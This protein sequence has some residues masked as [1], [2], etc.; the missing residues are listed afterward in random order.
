MKPSERERLRSL[1]A[2]AALA[3]LLASPKAGI[4]A[5]WRRCGMTKGGLIV[6]ERAPVELMTARAPAEGAG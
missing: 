4:A 1:Y 5:G 6:L 2:S 3:G